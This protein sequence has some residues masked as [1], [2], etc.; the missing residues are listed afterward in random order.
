MTTYYTNKE[1]TALI[2]RGVSFPAGSVSR[3]SRRLP[4]GQYVTGWAVTK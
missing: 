4:N 2:A 3:T 1:F